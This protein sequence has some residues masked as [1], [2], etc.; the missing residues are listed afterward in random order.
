ML[1]RLL[2]FSEVPVSAGSAACSGVGAP[3]PRWRSAWPLGD[4]EQAFVEALLEHRKRS[5]RHASHDD[6]EPIPLG[7]PELLCVTAS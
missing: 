4:A 1:E 6:R 2:H 5:L 7:E 3:Q